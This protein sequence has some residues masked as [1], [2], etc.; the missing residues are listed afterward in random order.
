MEENQAKVSTA[1]AVKAARE[2]SGLSQSE[3]ASL[4]GMS[5]LAVSRIETGRRQLTWE[6]GKALQ[7]LIHFDTQPEASEVA[8][9][10][11]AYRRILKVIGDQR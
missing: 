7:S 4:L 11:L 8:R 10:A 9:D 1:T 2:K 6:E 3:L 5:T